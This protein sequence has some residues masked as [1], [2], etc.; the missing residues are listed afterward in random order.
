MSEELE[1]LQ[2][3]ETQ[4]RRVRE[5]LGRMVTSAEDAENSI[6]DL[7]TPLSEFAKQYELLETPIS[8]VE[9]ALIRVKE[10]SKQA[11]DGLQIAADDAQQFANM[12]GNVNQQIKETDGSFKNT[13]DTGTGFGDILLQLLS[14][15][16]L[17][18]TAIGLLS[19]G[20][21]AYV[22]SVEEAQEKTGDLIVGGF[23]GFQEGI[24]T[25]QGYLSSFDDSLFVSTEKQIEV[26]KGIQDVQANIRDLIQGVMA[27]SGQYTDEQN[28]QLDEYFTKL[29]ELNSK[30]VAAEQMKSQAIAQQAAMVAETHDVSLEEYQVNAEQWIATAQDQADK[31]KALIGEQTTQELVLLNQRYGEEATMENEE[32]AKRYTA[33]MENKEKAIEAANDEV[34]KVTAAFA[35]GYVQQSGLQEIFNRKASVNNCS[36]EE[37]KTRHA[38][39]LKAIND[40]EWDIEKEKDLA[41]SEEA[42]RH[43]DN[44]NKIYQSLADDMSDS[45]T[46]RLGVFMGMVANNEL[47]GG[48]LDEGTQEMVKNILAAYDGF[49]DK[50]K[51]IMANGMKPLLTEMQKAEPKLYAKATGMVN[52]I[53]SR[54][55][56]TFEEQSP[57]K[58]TRKIFRFAMEGGLLGIE[59]KEE[60]L[61]QQSDEV[62]KGVI[63]RLEKGLENARLTLPEL[64]GQ[65]IIKQVNGTF[66]MAV[67]NPEKN[68]DELAAKLAK[69]LRE[70][71]IQV[72]STV[73]A[74]IEATNVVELDGER[75]GR[76]VA[77]T[78]SRVLARNMN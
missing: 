19:A 12:A 50:T 41:I 64:P 74:T 20:I 55:R 18:Q 22:K 17:A 25:A 57:S 75:V 34:G 15:S 38:E 71:P 36:L 48:E 32:Y 59:D 13:K 23:G 49:P 2:E 54:M 76:V 77:P 37:E 14:P 45:E 44:I 31:Q 62:A 6:G 4:I 47:Y 73:D 28:A 52:G 60:G 7:S 40:M 67:R 29:E 30:Q 68:S 9:N 72:Q 70:S 66:E 63:G 10:R 5:E 51:E 69:V 61:Y 16:A 33:L 27:D 43:R 78:V 35:D 58:A 39:R 11:T 56:K 3:L 46:K 8:L 53:L 42:G 24:Q 65:E 21:D 1:V 26:V